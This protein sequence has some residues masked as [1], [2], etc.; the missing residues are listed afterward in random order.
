MTQASLITDYLSVLS[1]Q[2]PAPLVEE[3]AMGSTE[4]LSTHHRPGLDLASP[5]HR[6]PPF[7]CSADHHDWLARRRIAGPRSVESTWPRNRQPASST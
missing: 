1:A 2:L 5:S 7:Q 4:R 3:L 6:P